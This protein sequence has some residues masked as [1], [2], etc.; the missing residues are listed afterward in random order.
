MARKLVD[1]Q[2]I[3]PTQPVQK[4]S[5]IED[6][7]VTIKAVRFMQG[8]YGKY[9]IM[10]VVLE[11][12]EVILVSTGAYLVVNALEHAQKRRGFPCEATFTREDSTWVI[13]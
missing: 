5:D 10:D 2:T 11:S 6:T 12:G 4:L 13:A 8:Q 3:D 7:E 1:Y 9:A